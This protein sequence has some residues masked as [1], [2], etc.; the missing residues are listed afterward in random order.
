MAWRASAGAAPH[1]LS[2]YRSTPSGSVGLDSTTAR[3][4]PSVFMAGSARPKKV[5]PKFLASFLVPFFEVFGARL[6]DV[7][8]PHF[9]LFVETCQRLAEWQRLVVLES[10]PF[11]HRRSPESQYRHSIDQNLFCVVRVSENESAPDQG[12]PP[13]DYARLATSFLISANSAFGSSET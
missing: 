11:G 2:R 3:T 7:Q 6:E 4:P 5:R 10:Q 12:S 1:L 8:A 9:A 13:K